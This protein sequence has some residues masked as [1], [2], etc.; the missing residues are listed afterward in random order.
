MT[1]ENSFQRGFRRARGR[2]RERNRRRQ[3]SPVACLVGGLVIAIWGIGLLL[4]NLGLGDVRQYVHRAWPAVLV[5]VGVT[6][7]IHRD[8]SR[9]RYGFWGTVCLFAGS[10]VYA[11]Q[12]NWIHASFWASLGPILLVLLGASFVY[13][14]LHQTRVAEGSQ[15]ST[16]LLHP[17]ID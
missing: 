9:N 1:L 5:I 7:L 4:D 13:R 8:P 2:D 16:N 3:R 17:H 14:A 10:W 6:L 11:S 12:Q 15:S